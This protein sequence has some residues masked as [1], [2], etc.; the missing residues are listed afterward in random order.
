MLTNQID[1]ATKTDR[2]NYILDFRMKSPRLRLLTLVLAHRR[3]TQGETTMPMPNPPP[4]KLLLYICSTSSHSFPNI[5]LAR[6][7]PFC[8]TA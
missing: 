1:T 3:R 7:P 4:V 5:V 6:L 2:V 8:L